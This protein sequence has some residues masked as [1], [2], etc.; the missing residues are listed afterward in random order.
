MQTFPSSNR[1]ERGLRFD[2][3]LCQQRLAGDPGLATLPAARMVAVHGH[4][5]RVQVAGPEQAPPVLL[6]PDPPHTLESY[7]EVIA[8]VCAEF[9]VI[10]FESPGFGYSQPA[11]RFR[12]SLNE[13][14]D[15]IAGLL[16]SCGIPANRQIVP[17]LPCGSGFAA[18]RFAERY[19][20]QVRGLVAVQTP[21][22]AEYQAWIERVDPDQKLRTP[23]TGQQHN[24]AELEAITRGW[25]RIAENDRQQQ[26]AYTEACLHHQSQGACYCLASALQGLVRET[27]QNADEPPFAELRL[28]IPTAILWGAA[29]KTYRRI[30]REPFL[31]ARYIRESADEQRALAGV[32]H[33]PEMTRPD[34]LVELLRAVSTGA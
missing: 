17:A 13:T 19:P 10:A 26:S 7:A 14:A 33:F 20:G 24:L 21:D 31:F 8:A 11:E 9:R 3:E 15:L 16:E 1:N 18:L 2:Y 5:L 25:L 23:H 29:D 12:F 22:F 27:A 4:R 34:Q 32:G 28:D 30:N 6:C